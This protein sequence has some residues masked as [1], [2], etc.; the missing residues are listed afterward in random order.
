MNKALDALSGLSAI[1][2]GIFCFLLAYGFVSLSPKDPDKMEQWRRKYGRRTK[3][4][5]VLSILFGVALLIILGF[6]DL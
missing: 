1:A 3:A 2:V 5:G 6:V 4:I